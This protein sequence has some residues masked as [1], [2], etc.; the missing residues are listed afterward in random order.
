[1][2]AESVIDWKYAKA[3]LQASTNPLAYDDLSDVFI[4]FS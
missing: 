3:H 1:M 2:V 4:H